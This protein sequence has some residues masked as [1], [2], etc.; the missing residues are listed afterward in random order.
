[1]LPPYGGVTGWAGLHWLGARWFDEIR[2]VTLAV[3]DRSVR[4]QPTFGIRTSEE[5]LNPTELRVHRGLRITT[6]MRSLF[7]EMRYAASET[8]ATQYAEMAAYDDLVSRAELLTFLGAN[9]GW[10]GI[11]RARSGANDMDENAWSPAEV[12]MRRAWEH[13]AELPRPKCNRPVFDLGGRHL[14]T[15]DLIDPVAGVIGEYNGALHLEGRQRWIDVTREARFRAAGLE[16]VEMVAGD[17]ADPLA[18]IGRLR[19]AYARAA[20]LAVAD[21]MWTIQ[22]P[23]WWIPTSTVEQR[24]RLTSAQRERLLGYRSRAS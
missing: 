19:T 21:R 24:R 1:M 20:R 10:T 4:P 9:P 3:A 13:D 8:A 16:C 15:P 23:S 22:Q 18:F 12:T 14:G 11:D 5:R 6:A 7:F 2:P 17:L